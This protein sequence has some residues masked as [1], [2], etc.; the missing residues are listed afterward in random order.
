MKKII[1]SITTSICIAAT[2][3]AQIPNNSFENWTSM[4]SYINPD[5]WDQLNAMTA[6]MGSV[7]TCTK[8]TPGYVGSSYLKLTSQ[9]ISMMGVMP[10]IAA[11][12]TLNT[13]SYMVSGGFPFTQRPQSI[14]GEWQYMG[15]STTDSAMIA[16]YLTQWNTAMGMRD[17]VAMLMSKTRGMAMTWTSF[18]LNLMYMNGG[19]PDTAQIILASGNLVN[20]VSGS[21]LF[22]D[23]LSFAGSVAGIKENNLHAVS[24]NLFPNPASYKLVINLTNSKS[25]KGQIDIYDVIGK[26]VKSLSDVDFTTNTI[27]DIADL[28]TGGYFVKL[29]TSD[30]VITKKFLKQ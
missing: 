6:A 24:V 4:G 3:L 8:G 19:T 9:T 13:S 14:K 27:I 17:T 2:A 21:Y 22:V 16:V 23:N 26:K 20:P 28:N 25:V 5:N 7:Y 29:S 11:T 10:G 18:N 30:E 15:G 12:G 1:L